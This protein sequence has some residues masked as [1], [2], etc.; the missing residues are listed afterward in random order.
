M[1]AARR[2][3]GAVL[4][5]LI[6]AALVGCAGSPSS[7]SDP[8]VNYLDAVCPTRA[9]LAAATR[10]LTGPEYLADVRRT[11]A[12]ARDALLRSERRL[13]AVR[14][15]APILA[16]VATLRAGELDHAQWFDQSA[17][18]EALG[19]IAYHWNP[20]PN[21]DARAADQRIRRW[22]GLPLDGGCGAP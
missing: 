18:A 21:A 1:V 11:S 4:P 12:A 3:S 15:P 2:W 5:A 7:G 8:R 14:W 19:V 6:A 22:I 20:S 9:P 17:T 16:D 13:A 10:A